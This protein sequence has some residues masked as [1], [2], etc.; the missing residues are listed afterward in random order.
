M[1]AKKIVGSLVATIAL[2]GAALVAA[3]ASA[4]QTNA[5]DLFLAFGGRGGTVAGGAVTNIR[6]L[7]GSGGYGLSISSNTAVC[8]VKVAS[9]DEAIALQTRLSSPNVTRIQCGD[10]TAARATYMNLSSPLA[11]SQSLE[12]DWVP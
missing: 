5:K 1:N 4:Q 8:N 10:N 12:F 6:V 2:A 3:P 7:G 9:L 11:A